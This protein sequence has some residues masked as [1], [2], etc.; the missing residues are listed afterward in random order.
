MAFLCLAEVLPS[1]QRGG[2]SFKNLN[3]KHVARRRLMEIGALDPNRLAFSH[4]QVVHQ[5]EN[6]IQLGALAL[7]IF[8]PPGFG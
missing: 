8:R 5:A 2:K 3:R 4:A 1:L 7:V 6:K